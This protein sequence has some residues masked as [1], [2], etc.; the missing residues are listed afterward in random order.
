MFV[1]TR[2]TNVCQGDYVALPEVR[3]AEFVVGRRPICRVALS[4]YDR[5]YFEGREVERAELT[6]L[7][8]RRRARE[9]ELRVLV[10]VDRG[11]PFERFRAVVAAARRAG[12]RTLTLEVE[13]PRA[14]L[15]RVGY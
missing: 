4:H 2:P 14:R 1:G 11:A 12:L 13:S 7:L 15:D 6:S 8:A 3:S 9:P 10:S 5:L